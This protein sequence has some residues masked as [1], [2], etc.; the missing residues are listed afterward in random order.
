MSIFIVQL[1]YNLI[2]GNKINF[3]FY[4]KSISMEN[5]YYNLYFQIFLCFMREIKLYDFNKFNLKLIE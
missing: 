5:N 2:Y 4:R 1:L 3:H